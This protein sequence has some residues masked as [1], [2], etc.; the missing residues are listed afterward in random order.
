MSVQPIR[1]G[2]VKSV[3]A[4]NF[5]DAVFESF[6]EL[7]AEKFSG[8]AATL[9]QKDV[10]ARMVSKGL[11]K[12]KIFDKGWLDVEQSYRAVGWSVIYDKPAYNESYEPTFRFS[13]K[14]D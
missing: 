3:K 2:E 11:K 14:K 1:P 8:G 10:V 5:P 13:I 6:N 7:I 9:Q 4:K 12:K